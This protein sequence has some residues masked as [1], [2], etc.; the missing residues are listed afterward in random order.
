MFV[1]AFE[2]CGLKSKK[3]VSEYVIMLSSF[4]NSIGC[5]I[6]MCLWS[7]W[8]ARN[9]RLW[10][11]HCTTASQIVFIARDILESWQKAEA[12]KAAGNVSIL[13]TM[14]S[15]PSCLVQWH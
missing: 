7:I 5:K 3:D 4:S 2:E 1:Y 6:L 14:S 15:R 9:E 10:Q 12:L 8:R 11:H 13:T